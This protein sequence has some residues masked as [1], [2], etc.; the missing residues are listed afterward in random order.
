MAVSRGEV[1]SPSTP[2]IPL[3]VPDVSRL[4]AVQDRLNKASY[5]NGLPAQSK[6]IGRL[7]GPSGACQ[8]RREAHLAAANSRRRRARRVIS[9]GAKCRSARPR[10]H[11]TSSTLVPGVLQPDSLAS[12]SVSK[13]TGS[14]GSRGSHAW[15]ADPLRSSTQR[16]QRCRR[17]PLATTG[18]P[19]R[20]S[21][22]DRLHGAVGLRGH[23]DDRS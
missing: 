13:R 18:P 8:P 20:S 12:C 9:P 22:P 6:S 14:D 21:P 4:C 2:S 16:A 17:R 7:L 3:G 11:S 23:L 19:A 5:G 10:C 1:S 15:R